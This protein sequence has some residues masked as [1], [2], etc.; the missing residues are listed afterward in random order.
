MKE[1]I[2]TIQRTN[3]TLIQDVGYRFAH[4]QLLKNIICAPQ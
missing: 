4:S 3:T 2:E 1:R